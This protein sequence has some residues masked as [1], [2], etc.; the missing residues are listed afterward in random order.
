MILIRTAVARMVLM[1]IF[2]VNPLSFAWAQT[3][4]DFFAQGISAAEK[5]DYKKS[6]NLFEK[7]RK[8]GMSKP[9]LDFNQA[10][11]HYRLGQYEQARKLF[12]GLVDN[13][14]FAQLAYFNLGLIANKQ[15]DEKTAVA[16]FQKAYAKDD[17][18]KIT[19]LA[20]TALKRLGVKPK[21][22][23][24][25]SRST[26]SGYVSAAIASDSNVNLA[27]DEINQPS[28]SDTSFELFA[29]GNGWLSGSR[30]D[31]VRLELSGIVQNYS[32]ETQYNFNLMH[33]GLSRFAQLGDWRT[34]FNGGWDEITVN[35]NSYERIFSGMVDARK[36]L[37]NESQLQLRYRL[38]SIDATDPAY[39]YLTG[40]RHQLRAGLQ[41][42]YGE[43]RVR[44]YYQYEMND[45]KD[46]VSP[47]TK[48]FTSYSPNRHTINLTGYFPLVTDWELRLD[49]RYRLS[50]YSEA[51]DLPGGGSK[52]RQDAQTRA[53]ARIAY[54]MAKRQ[55]VELKY[56]LTNND[57]N[58]NE[59]DYDR[60]LIQAGMN[61]SF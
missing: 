29:S 31:G 46:Y 48:T 36:D 22:I 15:K 20:E 53:S 8:A 3:A 16:W 38:S 54:K 42:R 51:N 52:K 13:E 39:D 44:A 2:L 58:I 32:T 23:A 34:R 60:T 19:V 6:L 1:I 55:E 49:G 27:T 59:Y 61:W 47:V 28:K 7:A 33:V 12:A 30:R 25:S 4:D 10:V 56:S 45:R 11:S 41:K 37:T 40:I 35:G 26:W 17:N 9:S 24:R 57:S 5:G 50:S 43:K 14:E 21:K 18:E